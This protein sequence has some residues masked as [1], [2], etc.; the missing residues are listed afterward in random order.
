MT[1]TTTRP[2]PGRP[3]AHHPDTNGANTR[4]PP[5]NL[6]AEQSLLGA[7]LLSGTAITAAATIVR[8]DDFYKP[9]HR[10]IWNTITDLRDQGHPV[11]PVTVAEHLERTGLLQEAGGPAL[12][13]SLQT[14]T[15]STASAPRYARIVAE[16]AAMRELIAVG[17][18][19]AEIGWSLPADITAATST[20]RA[21]L[22]DLV[23][24]Q[25]GAR[26]RLH[27]IG[28]TLD[29]YL[30]LLEHRSD[31]EPPGLR[32]GWT[33][34]DELLG[35]LRAGQLIVVAGR[36]GMGKSIVGGQLARHAAEQHVP[37]LVVSAEMGREELLDRQMA[38]VTKLSSRNLRDG[39]I[40][41]ND[42]GRIG[43]GAARL[44]NVPLW[45]LDD[46]AA[47]VEAARAHAATILAA[48]ATDGP[49]P[50]LLV[51]DYLQ[52]LQVSRPTGNR[53]TDIGQISGG[54]KRMAREL[55]CPVVALAQLNRG[56]EARIDKRP[57]LPDLR[58]SGSIENDADVVIGLYRDDYYNTDSKEAGTIEMIVLKQRSGPTGTARQ[59]FLA[60]WQLIAELAR[61]AH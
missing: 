27:L 53:V 10:H 50:A 15:P 38:A 7:C 36:P 14:G 30:D 31:G 46:E 52:L 49:V 42:W 23:A 11:D 44:A 24:R 1:D 55:G 60:E 17:T 45:I 25:E 58:E 48:N 2:A 21:L 59:A 37:A 26:R 40:A 29:D 22:D 18:E 9:A 4:V 61:G 56:L 41:P 16:R 3:A 19:I 6:Q 12:L 20:A 54:L 57:T 32:T 43:D 8:A 13:I 28:D 35:G 5:S 33:Q 34:L 51:V 39:K 47:T